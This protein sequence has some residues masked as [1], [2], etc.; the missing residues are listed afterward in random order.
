MRD[1]AVACVFFADAAIESYAN[2]LF[3]DAGKIFPPQFLAGL[4]ALWGD[5][6]RRK[7]SIEKLEIALSLKDKPKL[8]HKSPLVKAMKVAGRLRNEVTH[9]KPE[10]SHEPDKH[11]SLSKDHL[12][13]SPYFRNGLLFPQAWVTHSCTRWIVL[14]TIEFLQTFESLADLPD[15]T[16]WQSW[17]SR[18]IP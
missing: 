5:I 6:E 15:R 11:A 17:Q 12:D 2:E 10:W 4:S 3:A 18:L 1:H 14:T 16:N 7:S 13:R 8:D 9:F